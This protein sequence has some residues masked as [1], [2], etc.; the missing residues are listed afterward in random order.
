MY[1][2]LPDTVDPRGPK[3]GGAM[4]PQEVRTLIEG[5]VDA[6][7]L[8]QWY[9]ISVIAAAILGGAIAWGGS[10]LQV[11]AHN[12]AKKEDFNELKRQL[13]ETTQV[14]ESIKLELS[15]SLWERQGRLTLKY[16]LYEQLLIALA[17]TGFIFRQ[18]AFLH[19]KLRDPAFADRR[20]QTDA[21]IDQYL[22]RLN[23]QMTKLRAA[24]ALAPLVLHGDTL[25]ALEALVEKWREREGGP[26]TEFY[27]ST[28]QA[29][30]AT[31]AKVTLAARG[32]LRL[33]SGGHI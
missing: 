6:R 33:E 20:P 13:Q 16:H 1:K 18:L 32:D 5:V 11:K 25:E 24:Q 15:G 7:L 26:G 29:V 19:D 14:A 3:G 30:A 27:E 2:C 22:G 10:Y 8:P 9:V 31:M 4:S 21:F 28:R 23:E 12:F 17:D